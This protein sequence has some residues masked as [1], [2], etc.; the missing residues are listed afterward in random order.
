MR[1]LSDTSDRVPDPVDRS[2]DVTGRG[3]DGILLQLN[4]S[5]RDFCYR[6]TA[7]HHCVDGS[8]AAPTSPAGAAS[9]AALSASRRICRKMFVTS[10]TTRK[11]W[12]VASLRV[13][14]V[15][16]VDAWRM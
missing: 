10:S 6:G 3:R 15:A 14:T 8:T 4:L 9:L 1:Q 5:R 12:P 7:L 13:A 11:I 16:V 2:D